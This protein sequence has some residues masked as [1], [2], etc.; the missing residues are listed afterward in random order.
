MIIS[1]QK[2]SI[3][4]YGRISQRF[5]GMSPMKLKNYD[6]Q[7]DEKYISTSYIWWDIGS[8]SDLFGGLKI[9]QG[10]TTHYSETLSPGASHS[11]EI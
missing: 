2:G 7:S 9:K 10:I 1:S 11:I 4:R 3:Y 6:V 8:K 5:D